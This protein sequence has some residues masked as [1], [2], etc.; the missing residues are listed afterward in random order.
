MIVGS[1]LVLAGYHE[2]NALRDYLAHRVNILWSFTRERNYDIYADRTDYPDIPEGFGEK[3]LVKPELYSGGEERFP[4]IYDIHALAHY[5]DKLKGGATQKKLDT[6]IDYVLDP[7]YQEL[8]DGYGLMRAGKRRYYAIGWSVHLYS[9]KGFDVSGF[10]ADCFVQ[11]LLL[12]AHFPTARKHRWFQ[13]SLEHLEGFRTERGVFS[14]PRPYLRERRSGY[15]VTGA[16]MGLE[17]DRRR[18]LAIELESTFWM[19]KLKKAAALI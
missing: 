4:T 15:W 3:P 10:R 18:R 2:D 9:Y 16:Y 8:P 7:K 1:F 11:R 5:P 17:E 19:L 13:E 6:V 12:L 14:F